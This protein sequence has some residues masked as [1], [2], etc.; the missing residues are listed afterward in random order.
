MENYYL[1]NFFFFSR[2]FKKNFNFSFQEDFIYVK[3]I[4]KLE[5]KKKFFSVIYERKEDFFFLLLREAKRNRNVK[6]HFDNFQLLSNS[7]KSYFKLIKFPFI[8]LNCWFSKENVRNCKNMIKRKLDTKMYLR[9]NKNVVE[10]KYLIFQNILKNFDMDFKPI[11]DEFLLK[12]KIKIF[13]KKQK[14][15]SFTSVKEIFRNFS[16]RFQGV[17]KKRLKREKYYVSWKK[18]E[19]NK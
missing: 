2:I 4:L 11:S 17:K 14:D 16:S 19:K 12:K 3:K 13:Q 9:E 6:I 18:F 10:F 8:K 1:N 5:A 15:D 7:K